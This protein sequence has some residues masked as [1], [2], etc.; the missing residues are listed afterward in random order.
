M[1]GARSA[2][3]RAA[4]S[5]PRPAA[6][7]RRERPRRKA[8]GSTGHRPRRMPRVTASAHCPSGA[9]RPPG[10]T[11]RGSRARSPPTSASSGSAAPGW[12][13]SAPRS[14]PARASSAS[15]PARSP[16][17]R[18]A[19]TA[20]SCSPARRA[21]PPRRPSRRGARE[22]AVGIYA[23]SL[24]RARPAVRGARRRSCGASARCGSRPRRRRPR[25]AR[26][27][28]AA[29]RARRLPGARGRRPDR[30][31]GLHPQGRLDPAARAL[32]AAR[33]AGAGG[34]ARG[35][36]ADSPATRA[37]RRP[38]VDTPDGAVALQVR[39]SCASTAGSSGVLPELEG[40]ARSSRLQMLA[41]APIAPGTVPCPVYDNWG[42][43]Y[44]Q[45]LPDGRRR[46]RRRARHATPTGSGGS[47]PSPGGRRCRTGS[48]GC[49]ASASASTRR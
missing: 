2:P 39:S 11:R 19:A 5:R 37:R 14:T 44:W 10:R 42:Y 20:A 33:R 36:T 12:R 46:P 47:R 48:T 4:S 21:V 45:Q 15:T 6:S 26:A 18:P 41:T 1:P 7:A 43:E 30:A 8:G 16:A 38:R 25:T 17:A 24:R 13:R 35:C 32:P 27:Q 22:R 29:L 31:R 9:I 28:L 40:R 3:T 49:C 34:A 23:E